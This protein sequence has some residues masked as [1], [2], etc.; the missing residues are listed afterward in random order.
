MCCIYSVV[1][2]VGRV[3]DLWLLRH[4]PVRNDRLNRPPKGRDASAESIAEAHA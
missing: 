2:Q 3:A 4:Q 1:H